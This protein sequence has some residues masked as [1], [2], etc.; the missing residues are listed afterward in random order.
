[1]LAVTNYKSIFKLFSTSL[2]LLSHTGGWNS[3]AH[4]LEGEAETDVFTIYVENSQGERVENAWV[5][6]SLMDNTGQVLMTGPPQY[7][8]F[9]HE[10]SGR[11]STRIQPH[12]LEGRKIVLSVYSE[13]HEQYEEELERLEREVRVELQKRFPQRITDFLMKNSYSNPCNRLA[14]KDFIKKNYHRVQITFDGPPAYLFWLVGC[15]ETRGRGIMILFDGETKSYLGE[16]FGYHVTGGFHF[17][18]NQ[19]NFSNIE[20]F[21]YQSIRLEPRADSKYSDIIFTTRR[22]IETLF[23]YN[24]DNG[25]YSVVN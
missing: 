2:L 10:G 23:R 1:M 8:E 17:D 19:P 16:T 3:L 9:N 6:V 14:P 15:P 21:D 11:Y 24:D 20:D 22:N 13:Q 12:Q 25:R 7:I 18:D 4:S 5:T